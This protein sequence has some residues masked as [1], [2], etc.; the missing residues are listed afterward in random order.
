M[1]ILKY[2]L[3]VAWIRTAIWRLW[4]PFLTRRLKG[5]VLFLNYAF[6]TDPPVCCVEC[7]VSWL[8]CVLNSGACV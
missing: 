8:L 4:Y 6:E 3:S 2:L 1:S 7:G 5:E